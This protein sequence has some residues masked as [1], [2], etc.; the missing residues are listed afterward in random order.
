MVASLPSAFSR[1]LIA[2]A[3]LVLLGSCG[4]PPPPAQA[5][6][7]P[8]PAEPE[9]A[10]ATMSEECAALV[11]ALEAWKD[12]PNADEQDRY[13]IDAWVERATMDFAAATK[14]QPDARAQHAIAHNCRRATSSVLA[15]TERCS[16]GKK[17]PE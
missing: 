3:A 9:I 6:G 4:A 5:P 1:E 2:L 14:A 12:C 17:P 7:V 13:L 16:N 11:T 15:A 8:I 10:V